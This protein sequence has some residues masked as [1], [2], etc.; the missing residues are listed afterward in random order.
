MNRSEKPEV[1]KKK[2]VKKALTEEQLDYK[3][4]LEI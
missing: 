3:K 1:M 2:E 4:Y